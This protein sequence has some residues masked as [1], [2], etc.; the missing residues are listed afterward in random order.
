[1]VAGYLPW[2]KPEAWNVVNR[3]RLPPVAGKIL[4]LTVPEGLY[5]RDVRPH[6]GS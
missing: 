6:P 1:M 5:F 4:M 2:V 3:G